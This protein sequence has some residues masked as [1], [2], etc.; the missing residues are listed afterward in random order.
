[1]LVLLEHGL[2]KLLVNS[3]QLWVVPKAHLLIVLSNLCPMSIRIELPFTLLR[4][5]IEQGDHFLLPKQDLDHSLPLL[6]LQ[7]HISLFLTAKHR[8]RID[9]IECR[10]VELGR[11]LA[12]LLLP[13]G[14]LLLFFEDLVYRLLQ[15]VLEFRLALQLS[16]QLLSGTLVLASDAVNHL[17]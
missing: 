11:L 12:F 7:Q 4:L 1:M 6:L 9:H 2:N 3:I 13:G 15:E 16:L 10:Q 8:R 14:H 17:L 5:V